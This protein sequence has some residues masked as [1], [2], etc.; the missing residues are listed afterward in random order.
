MAPSCTWC[1]LQ[2]VPDLDSNDVLAGLHFVLGNQALVQGEAHSCLPYR[3][4]HR[5]LL[6]PRTCV[7]SR[8]FV[9]Q[10]P[11]KQGPRPR[12]AL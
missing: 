2:Q 1:G 11:D 3:S 5:P 9:G 12:G 6:V 10:Q 7:W 8:H 4:E